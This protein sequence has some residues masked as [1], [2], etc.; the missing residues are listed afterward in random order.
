MIE[1]APARLQVHQEIQVALR[2]RLAPGN[3]SEDSQVRGAVPP[4]YCEDPGTLLLDQ[5]VRDGHGSSIS[6][7][8]R[9]RYTFAPW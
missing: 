1:E 6:L 5:I 3:R 2:P 9:R 4:G 7:I 8:G